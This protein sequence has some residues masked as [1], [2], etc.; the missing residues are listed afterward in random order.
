MAVDATA[1]DIFHAGTAIERQQFNAA[2]VRVVETLC[3]QFAAA[4][5]LDEVAGHLGGDQGDRVGPCAKRCR[6]S[7][8]GCAT[9]G[10]TDLALLGDGHNHFHLAMVTTVPVP[11]VDLISNSLHR[12]RAPVR[13]RPRPLPLV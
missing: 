11:G 4:A 3:Q 1:L 12:R 8:V 9:A 7:E 13:P 2:A 5:V 6:A 10:F